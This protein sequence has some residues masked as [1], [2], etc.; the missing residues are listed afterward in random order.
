MAVAETCGHDRRGNLREEDD[1]SDVAGK[2]REWAKEN[3]FEFVK[4]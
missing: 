2:F 1:V 4:A 3:K